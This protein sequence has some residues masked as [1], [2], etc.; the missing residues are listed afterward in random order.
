MPNTKPYEL[1]RLA[2]AKCVCIAFFMGFY[3]A[4]SF[5]SENIRFAD[6]VENQSNNILQPQTNWLE[7]SQGMVRWM[8]FDV[9]QAKLFI[10]EDS[11]I[12]SFS[13]NELL[14]EKMP[15]KL[16]LC[17]K[18]KVTAQ[19]FIEGAEHVL[20]KDLSGQLKEQVER[21]HSQYQNVKE[22]DCY[23]L[24][25]LPENQQTQL[26]FNH[27]LVFQTNT[28]HFKALY[29]GIWIGDKPLS[30]RLKT[31]LLKAE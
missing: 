10:E 5:A 17:Y 23:A 11:P 16:E 15:L 6:K 9:Y 21:L 18:R 27:Q 1:N 31:T 3:S 29:F 13:A 25:Y 22:G 26:K 20:P 28:K 24:V 19:Q 4:S 14:S 8:W 2:S 7:Y 12:K 30:S